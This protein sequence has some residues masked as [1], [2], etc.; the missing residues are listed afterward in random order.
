MTVRL[1]IKIR[2]QKRIFAL[3]VLTGVAAAAGNAQNPSS[4]TNPFF[5]S[6]T[7]QP[8][9][10]QTIQL[11]LDD[12]IRRGLETNLG[13]REAES[14]EKSIHGQRNV[15]L[16]AFLPT[17]TLRGD[18]GF[19][20]HNLAALGFSPSMLNNIGKF[21]P[22]GMLPPG[23][24]TITHDTLTE[25]LVHFDWTLF[26]GP[27]ISGWKAAGAAQQAA[28]FQKMSARGETVQQVA[29][30][31][32]RCIADSSAVDYAKANIAQAQL[33]YNDQHEAHLAGTVASLEEFR[34]QV[35]LQTQQ[36]TLIVAQN[37]LD[38]DLIL[39]KREIGIAPGQKI[40][41]TDPTPYSELD[42]RPVPELL[43]TAY[44]SRQD[45]LNL[46]S[47]S[48]GF[49]AIHTAYRSQR[50]PTLKFNSYYGTQTVATIGTHGV[51][52]AAGT[53]S[54]PIFR[55]AELR[56][57]EDASQAQLDAV[58]AQLESLREQIE[59]QVRTALLDVNASKQLVDVSRSNVELATRALSDVTER[60]QAGVDTTL[61][62]V[63][64]QAAL[65]AAQRNL[66]VSLF[67]YNVSK[68]S[69]ARAAGV[70]ETQYRDYL[71]R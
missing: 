30:T 28:Y 33:L 32:L 1:Q 71:G 58:N 65:T 51:F 70:L 64:A 9:T 54:V 44:R 31:Y 17:I 19:Y 37:A 53:L 14:G 59:Q 62:L 7:A 23:F 5:G 69:L 66:V 63:A 39:L 24:S 68:L 47:Q 4:V 38:K 67:A 25:G 13:L 36:Q 20:Q 45:Y 16:Q 12:A 40:T 60:V 34:S 52:M 29:N 10:D 26:S 56:G 6:V 42:S 11:S 3:L 18:T 50:W 43:A 49:K 41:L 27:V 46:Q 8:A 22:G 2:V 61:P 35:E 21:F 55:E 15:A 48:V 57:G